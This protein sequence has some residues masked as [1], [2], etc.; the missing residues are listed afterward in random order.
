M[1]CVCVC[2]VLGHTCAAGPD[3]GML[4]ISTPPMVSSSLLK[5]RPTPPSSW[6][7]GRERERER[8]EEEELGGVWC[9]RE[10]RE[11]RRE[12][13]ESGREE[14]SEKERRETRE[15]ERGGERREEREERG[16]LWESL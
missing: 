8:D 13:R 6:D 5:D 10:G 11:E 15:R 2:V 3:S 4:R 7:R 1:C 16:E 14:R 12:E 9:G